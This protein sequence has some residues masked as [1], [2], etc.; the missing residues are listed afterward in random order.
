MSE[1][2]I[3]LAKK[4]TINYLDTQGN[5][6]AEPYI[7]TVPNKKYSVVS[8][9]IAGYMPIKDIIEG[10]LTEDTELTVEYYEI[11]ND[12]A[13]TGLDS[14]GNETEDEAGIASYTVSGIGNCNNPKVAIPKEYNGK[15]VTQ[16]K[17]K[18]FSSNSTI[19]GLVI[20]STIEAVGTEAFYG[21]TGLKEVNIN[22]KNISY[23]MFCGCTNLEKVI[24]GENV[25]SIANRAFDRCAKLSDVTIQSESTKLF[26][27]AANSFNGCSLLKNF[28]VNENNNSYKTIDGVLYSIDGTKLIKYPTAKDD[29]EYT[30]PSNVTTIASGAFG[31]SKL[32][33]INIPSTIE[34]VGAE[35]FYG[36]TGL[37]EV[38]INLKNISYIMFCRCTNLEKVII[39]ENVESIA[40][41][42]FDSCTK[43]VQ[44]TYLGTIEEW[45]NIVKGKT[46]KQNTGI[47]KIVCSDGTITL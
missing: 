24:I 17:A 28:K 30:I 6:L 10:E 42:A 12:L 4:L 37:K 47:E 16:I 31:Y 39:G 7:T 3:E 36:S 23:I 2:E 46:W 26:S 19:Q 34:E 15:S 45:N 20:P 9:E 38:N 1:M 27:N 40:E 43:I 14:N 25:E 18:A 21:S 5:K 33:K 44:L 13:F 29:V 11:C 22:S 32:E 41:R 35:A 8:P